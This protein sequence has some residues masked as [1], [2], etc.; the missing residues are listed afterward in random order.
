[1]RRPLDEVFCYVHNSPP[2]TEAE[3]TLIEEEQ[4]DMDAVCIFL[5]RVDA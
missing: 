2:L 4:G 1:M 3:E 5:K